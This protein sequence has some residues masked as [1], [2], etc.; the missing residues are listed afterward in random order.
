MNVVCFRI[1]FLKISK[2]DPNFWYKLIKLSLHS[3]LLFHRNYK[4]KY[5]TYIQ[6]SY[7]LFGVN[8]PPQKITE[9]E[10]FKKLMGLPGYKK[11]H[12]SILKSYLSSFTVNEFTLFSDRT[13]L[14]K[15]ILSEIS[16]DFVSRRSGSREGGMIEE[17]GNSTN[18][19][20]S[21]TFMSSYFGILIH[22]VKQYFNKLEESESN[23]ANLFSD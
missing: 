7:K 6:Y 14:L 11:Y 12:S 8:K 10:E 21:S 15:K 19:Q 9:I 23:E 22:Y 17:G 1:K 2:I 16:G 13:D 5:D 18:Y 4:D 3:Q 20:K